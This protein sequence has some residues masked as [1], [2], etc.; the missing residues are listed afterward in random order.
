MQANFLQPTK[1][2]N[3]TS[4]STLTRIRALTKKVVEP[5]SPAPTRQNQVEQSASE[6]L[7][8]KPIFQHQ[9]P[10]SPSP[11]EKP[12]AHSV[13]KGPSQG[14]SSVTPTS[15]NQHSLSQD[16]VFSLDVGSA[17]VAP[18]RRAGAQRIISAGPTVSR[19]SVD[20]ATADPI[21][22]SGNLLPK[23]GNTGVSAI[24][25]TVKPLPTTSK[26]SRGTGDIQT[27][28]SVNGSTSQKQKKSALAPKSASAAFS[29]AQGHLA[30][31]GPI[32]AVHPPSPKPSQQLSPSPNR[33]LT[34]GSLQEKPGDGRRKNSGLAPGSNPPRLGPQVAP[35]TPTPPVPILG[36]AQP[37]R[38]LRTTNFFAPLEEFPALPPSSAASSAPTI[39][40][41]TLRR[42]RESDDSEPDQTI[43]MRLLKRPDS[44]PSQAHVDKVRASK[45]RTPAT[46]GPSVAPA[47][48]DEDAEMSD[49]N[50]VS[51]PEARNS[52]ATPPPVTYAQAALHPTRQPSPALSEQADAV[53]TMLAV[54][55]HHL[56]NAF[57]CLEY[58]SGMGAE[59][60]PAIKQLLATLANKSTMEEELLKKVGDLVESKLAAFTQAMPAAPSAKTPAPAKRT[61][62]KSANPVPIRPT[63]LPPKPK[64]TPPKSSAIRHHP[65]RLI[66][67]IL[68]PAEFRSKPPVVAARDA[69]NQALQEAGI[70]VQVAGVTYTAA[71]NIVV[72]ARP[73]HTAKDLLPYSDGI[74]KVIL[75]DSAVCEGR[76]DHPW[77]RVQVNTV[78]VWYQGQIMHPEAVFEELKW[79]LGD[80][81]AL[82]SDIMAAPPRWMCAPTELENKNHASVVFSFYKEEDAQRFKAA[83][84]YLI[85]GKW[86]RT[87]AYEDRPQVRYCAHCWSIEHLTTVCRRQLPRCR[88]CAADHS[89]DS[90]QCE[91]CGDIEGGCEHHP[92]KCCNC[93]GQHVANAYD[94]PERKRKLGQ[95]AKR[96]PAPARHQTASAP[97]PPAAGPSGVW[98]IVQP[99]GGRKT[100]KSKT[101]AK[102]KAQVAPQPTPSPVPVQQTA[103]SSQPGPSLRRT[104]SDPNLTP[105][106]SRRWADME[107]DDDNA[108][109]Y[110]TPVPTNEADIPDLDE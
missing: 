2:S 104:H 98:Q 74:A 60:T 7:M 43:K 85:W 11:K 8:G 78:P 68:N 1:S 66:L 13:L 45:K 47:A 91:L 57:Q 3:S 21:A 30:K 54:T 83:G 53:E 4:P 23:L 93:K 42:R 10:V 64:P 88:L 101:K 95:I 28:I 67:R 48:P 50:M 34:P 55:E 63:P 31:S 96:T 46:S 79:A 81:H 65:A 100:K 92:L 82:S 14:S 25:A 110:G 56:T 9:P 107:T 70:S 72:I 16:Q 109:F 32:P 108:S 19:A 41:K 86:C 49:T 87:A 73:P 51:E 5:F 52:A 75:G 99:A 103:A 38:A 61:T 59:L 26:T 40:P 106:H 80:D 12:K 15:T 18:P 71:G 33:A 44:S 27:P 76:E 17:D 105:R 84:A 24:S 35:R 62:V 102:S 22:L 97:V 37:Q 94:C 77:F 39:A 20:H 90:H 6:V 36:N 29:A 69:V 89:S 58:L